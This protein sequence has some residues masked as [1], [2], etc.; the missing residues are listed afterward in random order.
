LAE[1]IA[2]SALRISSSV[3]SE[4]VDA[5]ATPMLA[6]TE[7]LRLSSCTAGNSASRSLAAASIARAS[8]ES[9]RSTANSSPPNRAI[10]STGRSADLRRFATVR[11][12][13]SPAA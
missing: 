4:P 8:V 13:S 1:C 7:T 5:T 11:S 10:V 6:R 12:S 3:V 9:S 2:A